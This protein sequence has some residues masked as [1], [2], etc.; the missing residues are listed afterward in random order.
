VVLEHVRDAQILES[1]Q[2]EPFD[3]V[4]TDLMSKIVSA[5]GYPL[6]GPLDDF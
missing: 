6:M 3:Q 5:V 2:P 1:D 4:V